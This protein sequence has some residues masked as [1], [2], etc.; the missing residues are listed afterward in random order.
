M[1][2]SI[3]FILNAAM[4]VLLGIAA[5]YMLSFLNMVPR[6]MQVDLPHYMYPDIMPASGTRAYDAEKARERLKLKF[7]RQLTEMGII[8]EEKPEPY[9]PT[10]RAE[11]GSRLTP[12]GYKHFAE[13]FGLSLAGQ[14]YL[15][16]GTGEE[17]DRF[18]CPGPDGSW[19]VYDAG[20]GE[21]TKA[22]EDASFIPCSYEDIITFR[23]SR[24]PSAPVSSDLEEIL[25]ESAPA[26]DLGKLAKAAAE[27]FGTK[28]MTGADFAS[29]LQY[30]AAGLF[31][32]FKDKTQ[33]EQ[34][35]MAY[36]LSGDSRDNITQVIYNTHHAEFHEKSAKLGAEVISSAVSDEFY[37]FDAKTGTVG[38]ISFWPGEADK[39][40]RETK[41]G[42]LPEGHKDAPTVG[43]MGKKLC[44]V[45]AGGSSVQMMDLG[46]GQVSGLPKLSLEEG[47]FESASFV[48]GTDRLVLFYTTAKAPGELK[49]S[50]LLYSDL[51]D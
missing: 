30:R 50:E 20:S 16:P 31:L 51:E 32:G 17:K 19:Y 49:V 21:L 25:A 1:K 13:P 22:P 9:V 33:S 39:G 4:S 12:Y 41:V 48:F 27:C 3:V 47:S 26:Q 7:R 40:L 34:Q 46:S 35:G 37:T 2:R 18:Y 24:D 45:F 36:Y 15:V 8:E 11:A 14:G 10:P 38:K 29:L 5:V 42:T 43:L 44:A 23:V 28:R 6:S